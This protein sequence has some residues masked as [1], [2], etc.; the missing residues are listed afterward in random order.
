MALDERVDALPAGGGDRDDF[1]KRFGRVD[2]RIV[3]VLEVAD[4]AVEAREYRHG[5]S[6]VVAA[7]LAPQ[8]AVA[9][10][11]LNR[12]VNGARAHLACD[13]TAIQ[14]SR[15]V[16]GDQESAALGAVAERIGALLAHAGSAAGVQNAA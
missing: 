16:P 7:A 1:V 14:R 8:H 6:I 10:N 4:L 12:A 15:R 5:V 3:R 13:A 9:V 11:A 2:R